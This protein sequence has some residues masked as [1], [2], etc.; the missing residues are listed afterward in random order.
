MQG[1]QLKI[2]SAFVDGALKVMNSNLW[3]DGKV[4]VFWQA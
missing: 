4:A 2:V 1:D 3:I